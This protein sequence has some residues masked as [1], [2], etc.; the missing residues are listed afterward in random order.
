MVHLSYPCDWSNPFNFQIH[1]VYL[2]HF[3]K[4]INPDLEIN[5]FLLNYFKSNFI[6]C[7]QILYLE[8][9]IDLLI[10][11]FSNLSLS[12]KVYPIILS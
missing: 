4:L 1:L 12:I 11:N 3:F 2:L 10:A 6:I 9:L 7:H 5:N 8:I